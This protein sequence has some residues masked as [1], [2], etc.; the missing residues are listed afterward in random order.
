ME[1]MERSAAKRTSRATK[2]ETADVELGEQI[3]NLCWRC[4]STF[5]LK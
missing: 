4:M 5:S 3:G 2:I 1:A